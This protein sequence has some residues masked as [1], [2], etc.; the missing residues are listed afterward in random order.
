MGNKKIQ[1][2][3]F[4]G[5]SINSAVG[6]RNMS[7][8]LQSYSDFPIVVVVSAMGKTTNN[9]EEILDLKIKGKTNEN[10]CKEL[11]N[12]HIDIARN[13]F[14]NTKHKVFDEINHLF[15][16]LSQALIIPN[17]NYNQLYDQVIPYGELL[18][19]QILDN[20]LKQEGLNSTLLHAPDVIKT[21]CSFREANIDWEKT[22]HN[23]NS[24]LNSTMPG[25]LIM[26]QGFIAGASKDQMTT[27]GREGSDY[28]AAIFA[29][30][31]N[32]DRLTVWKDVPGI[33]N[34]DP[35]LIDDVVMY[36]ELSYKEASE[37]T[38]YGAKVIHPDTIKPL[39]EKNISLFVRSFVDPSNPGTHVHDCK[40]S[41]TVPAI[42]YK[43][44][45][46]LISF[47]FVDF[48]FV[49]EPGF[50]RIFNVL[51]KLNIHI[52]MMQNSAISFSICFDY[53]Q[54]KVDQL[55][56]RLKETFSIHYNTNLTLLTIKNH[57]KMIL[58]SYQPKPKLLLLE[59]K[60]RADYQAVFRQE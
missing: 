9:L 8:I 28:S 53:D 31:L 57:T 35:K 56:H 46:V 34:A 37:M 48:R 21:D 4:G 51:D 42:I 55:I 1:V 12:Y 23:I 29:C 60:S 6:V 10:K 36:K 25:E 47:G 59:Q 26:T 5:A 18:S 39:A 43:S 17:A 32:T 41:P 24:S 52:N 19:S 11:K 50:V 22:C 30:C 20:F 58:E 16:R 3:K 2:L 14:N 33:M 15:E 38:Y 54:N 13:L 27:L 49:N 40:S 45:Q 7:V 44:N